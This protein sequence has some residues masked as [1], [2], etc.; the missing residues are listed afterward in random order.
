MDALSIQFSSSFWGQLAAFQFALTFVVSVLL[1]RSQG[2]QFFF[3]SFDIR[4][5]WH[6]LALNRSH[7]I[8]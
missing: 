3:A 8:I 1:F 2:C 7:D 5:P 4:I 6:R